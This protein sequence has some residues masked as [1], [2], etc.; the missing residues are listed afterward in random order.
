MQA[1]LI[2]L[3]KV[4]TTDNVLIGLAPSEN[5][6][7]SIRQNAGSPAIEYGIEGEEADHS[8]HRRLTLVFGVYSQTGAEETYSIKER[9]ERLMT[10]KNLSTP[11]APEVSLTFKA[12][13]VRLSDSRVYPRNSWAHSLRIEFDIMVADLRPPTQK[14]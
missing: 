4:L 3:H 6:G 9:L 10:A 12:V 13:Q 2:Q 7:A 1:L 8:G 11:I 14:Q 5:I